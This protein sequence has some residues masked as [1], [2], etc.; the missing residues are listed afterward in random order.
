MDTQYNYFASAVHD[1]KSPGRVVSQE[2]RR[3]PSRPQVNRQPSQT[4][5]RQPPQPQPPQEQI[6]QQLLDLQ[7]F[8]LSQTQNGKTYF[9]QIIK[10]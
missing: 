10:L 4:L 3:R 6:P 9:N 8:G 5:S 1:F 2:G 7:N